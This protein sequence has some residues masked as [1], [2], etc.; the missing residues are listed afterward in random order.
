MR[1]ITNTLLLGFLSILLVIAPSR[2][3]TVEER[4]Q[5]PAPAQA[6]RVLVW[7]VLHGGND[8]ESGAEKALEI[9]R[10]AKPDVVLMQE[11]Y[12]ID[13][14]R[15]LLGPWIASELGWNSFQGSSTH[16]CI[17]TPLKIEKT[18]EHDVWHGV[19]AKLRDKAGRLFIAY[20]IWIDYRAYIG[21]HLR[22]HPEAT[23]EELLACETT[24]SQRLAE[25]KAIVEHLKAQEHLAAE[26]PLLVGG[27]F[28]CPSHLDW[29]TDT[30]IIGTYRRALPLPVSTLMA[31]TGFI[32]TYRVVH[33]NP[34]Q[35]PGITWTP[36]FRGSAEKP[37]PLDRIDRLYLHNPE[38]GPMLMPTAAEVL[39]KQ[40][41]PLDQP[42]Q[43]HD[44]P[45]DHGAVVIDLNWQD[46]KAT[47]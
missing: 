40:W 15:G 8:V 7:N 6:L 20:S 35:R 34:V 27:D 9:I 4:S 31:D 39:P 5:A 22:D 29:T 14:E 10:Q 43:Q 11:S 33:P 21:Y 45:S 42:A 16:L 47:D 28:N 26:V 3:Q 1:S 36:M 25:A 44:F 23:D 32:D 12:D 19:G 2:A 41:A 30:A 17:L 13:G 38:A 46:P 18:Y 24:N 37:Q